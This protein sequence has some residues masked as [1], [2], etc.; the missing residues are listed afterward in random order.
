MQCVTFDTIILFL[1][2]TVNQS[3]IQSA[4]NCL[5][6]FLSF[7][8][9]LLHVHLY[10]V[11]IPIFSKMYL[12]LRHSFFLRF[13]SFY[14]KTKIKSYFLSFFP[15]LKLWLHIYFS[16]FTFCVNFSGC[17]F[18]LPRTKLP[19]MK[20]LFS[21]ASTKATIL[22]VQAQHVC[23][24]ITLWDSYL[25][26]IFFCWVLISGE[27]IKQFSFWVLSTGPALPGFFGP[28]PCLAQVASQ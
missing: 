17:C 7:V 21:L 6:G 5:V 10:I 19:P 20:G 4:I 28:W 27:S 26:V 18:F 15:L 11:F 9:F 23:F 2:L 22:L 1:D 25:L 14:L 13:L 8:L 24:P 16:V 3:F 12:T